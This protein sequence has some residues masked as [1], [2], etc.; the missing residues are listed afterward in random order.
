[1]SELKQQQGW[2]LL[3]LALLLAG[4]WWWSSRSAGPPVVRTVTFSTDTGLTSE[5]AAAAIAVLISGEVVTPGRYSLAPGSAL[6]AALAAAG[7]PTPRARLDGI[8]LYAPLTA[9]TELYVPP[10]LD[11]EVFSGDRPQVLTDR[12]LLHVGRPPGAP[13][14]GG[15]SPSSAIPAAPAGAAAL[16][17]LNTATKEELM[18]L[19]RIGDKTAES[20]LD[21][22]RKVG[23]IRSL[24]E[25]RNIPRIGDKTLALL[26]DRI[27]L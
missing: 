21:Y 19:P 22:R 16:V 5:T 3:L 23:R 1:M 9:D 27:T 18:T 25:L 2:G 20:I 7:G 24:D 8:D 13:S 17:N 4:G 11:A 10:R 15:T 12:D 26:R 6:D 14:A